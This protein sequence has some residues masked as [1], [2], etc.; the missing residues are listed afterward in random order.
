MYN[1][2]AVLLLHDRRDIAKL[3]IA[4][5]FILNVCVCVCV[6]YVSV[7]FVFFRM[8]VNACE[9]ATEVSRRT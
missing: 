3:K 7:L 4:S 2:S 1:V 6:F 9:N 5:D 8:R